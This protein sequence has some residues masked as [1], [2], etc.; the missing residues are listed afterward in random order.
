MNDKDIYLRGDLNHGLGWYGAGKTFAGVN[1]DGPVLYGCA[2]G[3]LGTMCSS[4]L[5]VLAWNNIGNVV[6]DPSGANIGTLDHGL[7]FG[8]NNGQGIASR[9]SAGASQ[10]GLDFYTAGASRLSIAN[11]GTV[12]IGTNLPT[13]M[14]D[15]TGDERVRGLLRSGSESG[16]AEAPSPA[17]LVV[18]RINSTASALNSV[19]AVVRAYNNVTNI[20]LVRDGTVGGFQIRYPANS[21]NLTIACIG[22]DNTGTAR[23]YYTN[24]ASSAS[25][26]ALQIYPDSLNLVHFECT[27][28]ITYNAGQHL[29]QVTLSRFG[30]DNYWSG[31]LMST[32]NQ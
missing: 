3:G 13:A 14:L 27:F 23:N 15:V 8:A 30:G 2:G 31:T 22:I 11:N 29:T 28:G 10:F 20:T 7:T 1:V 19:V 17:G 24:L 32:Y 25:A 26:G 16:T 12:G 4:A 5:L 6:I 9:N 21:G 18:R